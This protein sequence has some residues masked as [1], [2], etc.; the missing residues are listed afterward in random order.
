MVKGDTQRARQLL[1]EDLE[2]LRIVKGWRIEVVFDGAARSTKKGPLG[3]TPG[4]SVSAADRVAKKDVSKHG[5][6]VVYT[7]SGVEA[8]S[9]IENRCYAA[10]NLTKGQFTGSFIVATDD[11]MIRLAGQNAGAFCMGAGRFVDELKSLKRSVDYRVEAAMAKV[12]GHAIRPEKLRGTSIRMGKLGKRAL[13][14]EDKRNRTKTKRNSQQYEDIQL[15][16][17][18]EEDENGVAWFMK[19]P[20]ST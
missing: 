2:N 19:L 7:G 4:Q 15:N 9:Y 8:D 10:R 16:I 6:R 18:V 12:N 5:V 17:E 13:I 3:D 14:I 1:I 20:V 11:T